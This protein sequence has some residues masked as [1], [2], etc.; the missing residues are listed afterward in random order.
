[1]IVFCYDGLD[2]YKV[3]QLG[4]TN[5]MMLDYDLLEVPVSRTFG[6]PMSPEVWASF[7][8]GE[9][10]EKVFTGRR[11]LGL[12]RYLSKLKRLFPFV[13]LG[14]HKK[15]VGVDVGSF[16]VKDFG[17]WADSCLVNCVNMPY[18]NYDN[19]DF[20]YLKNVFAVD[21]DLEGAVD[22]MFELYGKQYVDVV[23]GL[24]DFDEYVVNVV[25]F[26]V[27][28]RVAHLLGKSK[29]LDEFYIKLDDDFGELLRLVDAIDGGGHYVYV[30]SDHGYDLRLDRHSQFGF[31][32]CNRFNSLPSSIV[33]F[34]D[35]I[36][37]CLKLVR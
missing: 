6:I 26:G 37:D 5:F 36:L 27:P 15:F 12:A 14:L 31:V 21:K 20:E 17:S 7:L 22:F 24:K 30:V 29:V 11:N 18:I 19:S 25:Y 1:M 16:P 35:M 33:E 28:D 10:V 3:S 2:F 8:A 32:S 13:K 34:G 4:L 23:N 9:R